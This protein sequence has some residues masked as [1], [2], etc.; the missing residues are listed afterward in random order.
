MSDIEGDDP[1]EAMPVE[2][3]ESDEE[4]WCIFSKEIMFWLQISLSFVIHFFLMILGR[5]SK[6]WIFL[7]TRSLSLISELLIKII[8]VQDRSPS[9]Q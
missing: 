3:E 7:D 6:K 1:V 5:F 9:A 2:E 4:V 8:V